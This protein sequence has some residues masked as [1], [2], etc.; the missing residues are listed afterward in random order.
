MLVLALDTAMSACSVALCSDGNTLA[1]RSQAMERG[2]AEALLP[3]IEGIMAEGKRAY[4]DLDLVAATVG[5]GAFTG[6][7]IGLAAARGIAL[8]AGKPCAGVTT[9]EVLAAV[10]ANDSDAVLAAVESRRADLFVQAFDASGTSV[11]EAAALPP[12]GLP[13]FVRA[14]NLA[15]GFVLAGDGAHRARAML[16]QAGIPAEIC[17]GT[18]APDPALVAAIAAERH[19][20]GSALA[21][22]PFYLRP[23]DVTLPRGG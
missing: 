15:P 9:L 8:A 2:H 23:P 16:T 11:G 22:K 4:A 18:A 13:E 20:R 6:I 3:M 12:E 14:A 17:A 7:R 19:R 21:P 5:P 10:C 1:V